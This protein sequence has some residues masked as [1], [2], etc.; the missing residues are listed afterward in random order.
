MDAIIEVIVT[1]NASQSCIMPFTQFPLHVRLKAS[2][3]EG[4]AND[5]LIKILSKKL[6]IPQRN[7]NIFA[8]KAS[9]RKRIKIAGTNIT[10]IEIQLRAQ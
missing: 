5:E 2:P 7:F 9:R 3:Q 10:N 1:P 8:G 6:S 4:K